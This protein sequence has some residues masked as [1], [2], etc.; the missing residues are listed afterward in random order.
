VKRRKPAVVRVGDLV[1]HKSVL[2]GEHEFLGIV[3]DIDPGYAGD[4]IMV[5]W[6]RDS[7]FGQHTPHHPNRLEIVNESSEKHNK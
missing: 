7:G 5:F 3:T 2:A 6:Q 4:R 1:R